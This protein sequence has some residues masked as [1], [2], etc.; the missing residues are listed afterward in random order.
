M[1]RSVDRAIVAGD[2]NATPWSAPFRRLV[3]EGDLRNSQRGY[4]LELTFPT[5]LPVWLRI[6]IDH[7]LYTDGLEVVG[8][9]V[10]DAAGSDH[11]PVVVDF[12]LVSR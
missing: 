6:P 7:V 8:R 4:G 5:N 10:G 12:Q 11:L 9:S 3:A 2:F 1:R